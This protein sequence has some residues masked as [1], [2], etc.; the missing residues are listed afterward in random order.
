MN[1]RAA[2]Q[3]H[4]SRW[5]GGS[6][7]P[8]EDFLGKETLKLLAAPDRIES[9]IIETL[10]RGVGF[11]GCSILAKGPLLTDEQAARLRGCILSPQAHY[12]GCSIFKRLP[13]VPS[14]PFSR[15]AAKSRP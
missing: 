3:T 7:P 8:V 15:L 13:F 14:F 5:L 1:S 9:Y 11:V 6:Y 10:Q 4:G 2:W 12:N